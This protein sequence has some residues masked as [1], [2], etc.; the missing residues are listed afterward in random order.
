MDNSME[1][2]NHLNTEEP[3]D[4]EIPLLGW[5]SEELI[6]W[7]DM[8]PPRFQ[9]S[10]VYNSQDIQSTKMSSGQKMKTTWYIY[11]SEY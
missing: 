11:T 8:C 7:N 9:G 3:Y 1:D 10:P 2:P 6:I 4:P 5:D